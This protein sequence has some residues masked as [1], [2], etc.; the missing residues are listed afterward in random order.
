MA[1][2]GRIE[3]PPEEDDEDWRLLGL[4]RFAAAYCEEDSIYEKLIDV[5]CAPRPSN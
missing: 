1:N 3:L 4:E 2:M 5:E